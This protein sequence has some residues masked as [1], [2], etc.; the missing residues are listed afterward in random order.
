M[1][2]SYTDE[3]I[4]RVGTKIIR[5]LSTTFY[6]NTRMVFDELITNSRDALAKN[7]WV[8]IQ[9]DYITIEDD[10]IG[11]SKN[12]LTRFFYIS[13][14]ATAEMEPTRS[15]RDIKR[16]LI[17]QFGI[18]KLSLYQIC[19]Y[20]EIESWRDGILSKAR[21]DF[22]EFE[23]N[24]FVDDFRL[25]V[26]SE[27]TA[28]AGSGTKITLFEIKKLNPVDIKRELMSTMPIVDK[29]A[30]H[31][32]WKGL[33]KPITIVSALPPNGSV[34]TVGVLG[35]GSRKPQ[36]FVD[37]NVKGLNS[38]IEGK[39][40]YKPSERSET[41]RSGIYVRV[42]GR[43]VNYDNPDSIINF[44]SLTHARQ[45]ARKIYAELNVDDLND[46]LQTNRAGFVIDHPKY[47]AFM[48][49]LRGV[50]NELNEKEYQN[51][52]S[53]KEKHE[54][55]TLPTAIQDNLLDMLE[56][57]FVKEVATKRIPALLKIRVE[58]KKEGKTAPEATLNKAGNVLNVNTLHP[59]YEVSRSEGGMWGA[60][61]H[62]VKAG[63]VAI[64]VRLAQSLGEFKE[65][66]DN[67]LIED[68][69]QISKH[70]FKGRKGGKKK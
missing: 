40:I 14:P 11:M 22:S 65:I 44:S 4:I 10:G 69:E 27:K 15:F 70:R 68:V 38:P 3:G 67:M 56:R 32:K 7:V 49:W 2:N 35:K 30:V 31:I 66:Y 43:L 41:G 33:L 12:E 29:F 57:P 28:K 5:N 62:S 64:A 26:T 45:F 17:G 18:G 23:E 51:W 54:V 19:K 39:I 53:I 42:L 46:A 9:D 24:T 20:F 58:L 47:V 21:F 36:K 55:A 48:K 61:Y 8:D 25:N 60:L 37:G 52:V 13:Y 59:L 63:T 34:Y 1:T 50:L 16:R 6:P